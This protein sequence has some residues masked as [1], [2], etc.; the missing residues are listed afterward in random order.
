MQLDKS[1]PENKNQLAFSKLN[2]I[3][4]ITS[5]LVVFIGF[6]LMTI[7]T[8]EFGFGTLELTVGPIIVFTG[9][10]M[11][12]VAILFKPKNNSAE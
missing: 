9:F 7:K 4:M 10:M 1:N 8:A 2:Y 5:I 12:I 3:I 11:G 6:Y